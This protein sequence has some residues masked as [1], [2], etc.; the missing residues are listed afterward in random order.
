M[1]GDGRL[2]GFKRL[3]ISNLPRAIA[4]AAIKNKAKTHC[5]KGH[6]Y[7]GENLYINPRGARVCRKCINDYKRAKRRSVAASG[8]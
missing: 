6:A 4:I 2:D 5:P 8:G 1:H 7:S 3:A